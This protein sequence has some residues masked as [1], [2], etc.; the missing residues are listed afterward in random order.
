MESYTLTGKRLS[1]P[2]E[3]L[4]LLIKNNINLWHLSCLKLR[5]LSKKDQNP[6]A[7]KKYFNRPGWCGSV[8]ECQPV[9]QRVTRSIPGKGTSTSCGFS[10]QLLAFIHFNELQVN[11]QCGNSDFSNGTLLHQYLGGG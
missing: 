10:P 2:R 5:V 3:P 1:S 6:T 11:Q 7:F 9:H 8:G 4:T